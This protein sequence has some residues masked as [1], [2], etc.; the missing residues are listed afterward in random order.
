MLFCDVYF[1]NEIVGNK[2][3]FPFGSAS[4]P[5][6][7]VLYIRLGSVGTGSSNGSDEG[8]NESEVGAPM[9]DLDWN[10]IG[11]RGIRQ[12]R[13]S[14]EKENSEDSERLYWGNEMPR[15]L[16]GLRRKQMKLPQSC[17]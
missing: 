13:S 11:K 5:G 7:L 9:P 1:L 17:V 4:C 6:L 2:C 14:T 3:W 8:G 12:K 15:E 10:D 16:R